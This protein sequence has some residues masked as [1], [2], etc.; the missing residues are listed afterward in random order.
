MKF[1]IDWNSK[2]HTEEADDNLSRFDLEDDSSDL[3]WSRIDILAKTE[4]TNFDFDYGLQ[5]FNFT[6]QAQKDSVSNSEDDETPIFRK[7]TFQKRLDF[8]HEDSPAGKFK[9]LHRKV[10]TF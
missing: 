4:P 9:F 2:P 10:I 7:R 1:E 8:E 3:P 5:K 6:C